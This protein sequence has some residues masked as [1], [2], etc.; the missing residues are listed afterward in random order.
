VVMCLEWEHSK[1]CCQ[2]SSIW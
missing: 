1:S 2:V